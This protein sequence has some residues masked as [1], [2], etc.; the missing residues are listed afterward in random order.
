MDKDFVG[1][2]GCVEGTSLGP[3]VAAC[4][5]KHVSL[6]V[7]VG[8]RDGA[9]NGLKALEPLF[10]VLVPKIHHTVA[11]D[12]GKGPKLVV[13]A[14]GVDAVDI[15]VLSV[16]LEGKRVLALDF[17]YVVDRHTTLDA[18][19]GKPGSIGEA[20]DASR[21]EF[22]RGLFAGVLSRLAADIVRDDL[23]V[24]RSDHQQILP[25]IHCVN[26]L[27]HIQDTH[28]IRLPR[29]PEFKLSIPTT[30]D[31]EI[32]TRK[33]V[34]RLDGRVV[35]ANLLGYSVR[36]SP[37]REL[38]H[39]HCFICTTAKYCPPVWRESRVQNIAILLMVD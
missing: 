12:R 5:G 7:K 6:R 14:N 35:N 18:A 11:A 39:S 26:S 13:K 3:I 8:A 34:D 29:I 27:R 36:G 10:V 22:Q 37:S 1:C 24:G 17:L 28:R 15:S 21:L 33:K 9:L 25:H 2:G 31:H 19:H 23:T 4:V 20:S 30:T 32:G 38:P 16:T